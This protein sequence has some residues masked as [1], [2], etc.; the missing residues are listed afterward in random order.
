[1]ENKDKLE[2]R[3]NVLDLQEFRYRKEIEKRKKEETELRRQVLGR[4]DHLKI[5]D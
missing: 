3:S 1:M 2:V 4:I 5:D